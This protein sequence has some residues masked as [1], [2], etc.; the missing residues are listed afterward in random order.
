E[1]LKDMRK[2]ATLEDGSAKP[3]SVKLVKHE[4]DKSLLEIVFHEGR[5]HI[6]KRFV[7]H[8]G[9]KV[10][11]LKRVAIGPVSL[12]NLKPGQWR[13]LTREELRDLKRALDIM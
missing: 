13:E 7:S 11:R 12:G 10:L 8:F 9:H 2:G 5:K 6:V 1:T 4:G 3:D